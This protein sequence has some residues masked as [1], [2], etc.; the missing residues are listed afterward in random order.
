MLRRSLKT[1]DELDEAKAC[2]KAETE[3]VIVEEVTIESE[4]IPLD[5][6][7]ATAIESFDPLDPL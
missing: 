3:R 2:E 4:L 6:D 7:L 1:L 5:S